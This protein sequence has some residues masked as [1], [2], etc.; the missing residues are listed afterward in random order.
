MGGGELFRAQG[1]LE[2]PEVTTPYPTGTPCWVDL[3]AQDQQAALDFYRDLFGWQGEV[4][5]AD[6]GGY[7]VCTLHGKP[8]AGIGSAMAPE[9]QPEPPTV[10]TTYLAS[11][12]AQATQDTIVSAGGTLIAPVMDVGDIGRM[13]IAADPQGA[14]FGVWQPGDFHGAGIVNEP[15]ALI[16]NELNTSDVPGAT[17]FYGESFGIEIQP[18]EGAD[19]TY[20]SL[21]V[22]GRAVGGAAQLGD[23]RPGVPP[24]WL[25]YFAVDDVDSTVDALVK[26][27]GTVFAPPFEM[28][29]G[30]MAVVADPQGATFAV[31][32][33]KEM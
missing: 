32:K 10:W 18:M 2:M 33:P 14:V 8:V 1:E 23:D 15:G 24:H 17:G 20:W 11:T 3:M 16:W 13:L 30:R 26:R 19:G 25:T 22:G 7:A 5:G 4:G 21:N 31:F 28:M 6:F 12:D 9:G 27:N 29:A